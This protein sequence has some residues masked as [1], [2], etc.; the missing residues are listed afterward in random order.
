MSPLSA[1]TR[2]ALLS[3]G[4]AAAVA[5]CVGDRRTG[6]RTTTDPTATR[7]TTDP[8]AT[9]ET[10]QTATRTESDGTP[11]LRAAARVFPAVRWVQSPDAIRVTAPDRDAFVSVRLPSALAGPPA[12]AFDLRL[13]GAS[14]TAESF[15]GVFSETPGV[16]EPYTD[17]DS[18]GWLLFDVAETAATDATLVGPD[19]RRAR[20]PTDRLGGLDARPALRVV[21]VTTPDGVRRRASFEVIISVR[22]EGDG[23]GVWLGGIQQSGVYYTPTIIVPP[24]ETRDA[25]ARPEA[26]GQPGSTVRLSLTWAGGDRTLSVP[27]TGAAETETTTQR[28]TA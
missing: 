8:T 26:F 25:T 11:P 21:D 18:A 6:T 17:D 5:G 28:H 13:G 22:N 7:T 20:L 10:S 12:S 2:R 1:P 3:A 9:D 15:P 23:R 27:I 19:D 14:Y 24:G 4:A 16:R